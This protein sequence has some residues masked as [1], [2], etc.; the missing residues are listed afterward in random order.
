MYMS[1]I[2]EEREEKLREIDYNKKNTNFG[3]WLKHNHLITSLESIFYYSNE[4]SVFLESD[5]S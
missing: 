1:K 3:K 5:I 4:S 2:I